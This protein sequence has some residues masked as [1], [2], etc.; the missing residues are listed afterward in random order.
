MDLSSPISSLVPTLDAVVLEVLAGTESALGATQIHRHARRGAR[1][2]IHRVLDRL[3]RHGLI[4]AEGTNLG[5]VY[6]LN[7]DHV[8]AASVLTAA[9]ARAEFFTRLTQACE[10]LSP[11]VTS[12]ALFGSTARRESGTESDVDLLLVI[13]NDAVRTEAWE[14]QLR[15]LEDD[16]LAWT[17][18]GLECMTLAH[19]RLREAV[20]SEE[21]IVREWQEEAVTLTGVALQTLIQEMRAGEGGEQ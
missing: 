12:A 15:H 10:R 14:H 11:S 16:V 20:R 13:E 3:T 17:G 18:N 19:A 1:S 7:R 6:R 4:L 8:L 2:G 5:Y 21:P 9:G